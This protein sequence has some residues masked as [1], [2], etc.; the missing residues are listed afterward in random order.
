MMIYMYDSHLSLF[1]IQNLQMVEQELLLSND[2]KQ[3]DHHGWW[4]VGYA[5]SMILY[6]YKAIR[7]VELWK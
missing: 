5:Y 3:S 7:G 6:W 2:R 1:Q 4:K